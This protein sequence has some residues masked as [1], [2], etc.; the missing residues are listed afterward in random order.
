MVKSLNPFWFQCFCFNF[1]IY[2]K[3]FSDK[4][5]HFL[6]LVEKS[7]TDLLMAP[8]YSSF[9]KHGG[10]IDGPRKKGRSR[11]VQVWT[12]T[13][14]TCQTSRKYQAKTFILWCQRESWWLSGSALPLLHLYSLHSSFTSSPPP[15]LF[16]L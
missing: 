3:N 10:R 15:P 13:H 5:R 2:Y 7:R 8:A 12:G 1:K 14:G 6:G 9:S 16:F 4:N 11:W